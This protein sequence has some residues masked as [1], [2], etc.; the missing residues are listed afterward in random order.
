MAKD[1]ENNSTAMLILR[2]QMGDPSAFDRLVECFQGSLLCFVSSLLGGSQGIEDVIQGIWLTVFHKISTLR[3]PYVFNVWFYQIARR[4][5]YLHLRKTRR[6][7][8]FGLAEEQ[9][10]HDYDITIEAEKEETIERL[11]ACLKK[12]KPEYREVLMLQYLEQMSLEQIANVTQCKV[13]TI[14]SRVFYAKLAL[15]QEMERRP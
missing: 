12:I 4:R 13:G 2:C 9:V 11:Y 1:T 8:H 5:V 7:K 15:K 3:N 14:K 10:D 6:F